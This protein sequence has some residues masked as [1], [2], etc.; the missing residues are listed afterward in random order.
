MNKDKLNRLADLLDTVHPMRFN[1]NIWY[2][3][4]NY[5]F[6]SGCA[7][8]WAAQIFPDLQLCDDTIHFGTQQGFYALSELFELDILTTHRIFANSN[9]DAILPAAPYDYVTPK[10]VAAKIRQIINVVA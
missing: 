5:Q 4:E 6:I 1:M 3:V 7:G 2:R 9:Y 10:M 8:G